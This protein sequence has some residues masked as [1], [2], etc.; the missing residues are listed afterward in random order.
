L[1]TRPIV[2]RPRDA[3]ATRRLESARV[4]D[5]P[6]VASARANASARSSDARATRERGSREDASARDRRRAMDE[7]SEERSG[8]HAAP[9]GDDPSTAP[10]PEKV[11]ARARDARGRG[12]ARRAA[13]RFKPETRERRERD[14]RR[15]DGAR[16]RDDDA[17]LTSV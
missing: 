7:P 10:V 14:S 9:V 8:D 13:R 11:R 6:I 3:R 1:T 5:A 15:R 17:R 4:D 12:N 2:E 16:R